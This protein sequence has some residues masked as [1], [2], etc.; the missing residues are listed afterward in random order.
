MGNLE[1][2]IRFGARNLRRNPGFTLAA[3]LT[4]AL[5]IAGNATIFSL[6]SALLLRPLPYLH[7][8]RLVLIG[9][10]RQE[11][12]HT[13]T[14]PCTLARYEEI[15]DHGSSFSGVAAVTDDSANLTGNGEPEQVPIA[16]VT[17]N[18]F[19]LLGIRPQL[20]RGF[21]EE[22]GQPA[23]KPVVMISDS[24]W[25]SRFG[26]NPNIVGETV[27]LDSAPQTIIGV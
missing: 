15:R 1:Q 20:G 19:D 21:T 17:P 23:G 14:P 16:R 10:N 12:G 27:N 3:L 6:T 18:F 25:H 8:S 24:L 13:S 2:D 4:L 11:S 7:P 26:A 9:M 5:G 22:E